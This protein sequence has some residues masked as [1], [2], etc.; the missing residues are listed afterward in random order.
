MMQKQKRA[1]KFLNLYFFSPAGVPS[2][3]LWLGGGLAHHGPMTRPPLTT[4]REPWKSW[5]LRTKATS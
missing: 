5:I 2:R 1:Q 3:R 4:V